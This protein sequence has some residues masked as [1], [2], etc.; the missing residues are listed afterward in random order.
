MTA[1]HENET[2]IQQRC[3][4]FA[5]A[6]HMHSSSPATPKHLTAC[7]TERRRDDQRHCSA[8]ATRVVTKNSCRQ[9]QRQSVA[10]MPIAFGHEAQ[11]G[12]FVAS[13][14]VNGVDLEAGDASEGLA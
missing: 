9:I 8:A 7:S 1:M 6:D 4:T 14:G 13:R 12:K 2:R 5:A 10:S 3:S 11:R